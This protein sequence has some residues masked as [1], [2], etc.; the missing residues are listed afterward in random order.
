MLRKL[1]P[2]IGLL[3]IFAVTSGLSFSA[4]SRKEREIKGPEVVVAESILDGLRFRCIGPAIMGGRIDD[5]AVVEKKPGIIYAA[6]ASGGLWKTVNNGVTWEPIFDHETTSSIGDVAVSQSNPDIVWVGT[7][8]PNNRQSSSWGD[9]VFKSTDGGRTWKNMGLRETHHIGRVVIHPVNP[10]VVYVAA[11]GRLWG[12]N[13]ERGVYKTMDGGRTWANVKFIDEN[14]GFADVAMDPE[15]PDTLYAAAYE[16]RRTSFGFSGSGPGSG[17]YKTT[18]GGQTWARL[19]GGL[20]PGN[21]GRIGIDIYRGD[22]RIVYILFEHREGG[23]FRSEDKGLTWRKMSATNNRPMY[24]SQVRIDPNNDRHIWAAGASMYISDDGGRTF[25]TDVVTNIHGDYHAIWIDPADSDHML[26]GSDGGIHISY[27]R[28]LTWDF[29]NTIPLGQFY[30]V[31]F[32]MRQPYFVYGGLQDNG[33]WGGPN[34]TLFRLGVTNDEWFRVGGGDGFYAQVDPTDHNTVYAES[35]DGSVFRLDLRAWQSKSIRPRPEDPKETYRFNWNSPIL[36]SPH[37]PKKVYYGGNRLFV[38]TDRGDT[39]EATP[40]LTSQLDRNKLPILGLVP[41]SNMLSRHDGVSFYGTITTISESPVKPG[42]LWVG[43]DDGLIQVSEDN[44][45]TWKSVTSGISGVPK[46]TYVSRVNASRFA[47]GRAYVTFDGHRGDDFKPYVYMTEDFGGTWKNISAN[48]PVGSTVSVVRESLRNPDLLFAGT[49]RG[50]YFSVDRGGSWVMMKGNLPMVPVDDIAIHPRENDLI[51]ATHGRSIWV[52][53]DAAAFDELTKDTLAAGSRL[54]DIR[55]SMIYQPYGHKGS[56]GHKVYVAPN[57]PLGAMITYYLKEAAKDDPLIVISD[58]D[59]N[60][61]RTLK[62]TKTSGINR[63]V[64]DLRHESLATPA[65]GE[66][67]GPGRGQPAAPFVLPGEYKVS[68][69]AS[70]LETV[71]TA[72]VEADPRVEVNDEALKAQHDALLALYRLNPLMDGESSTQAELG[73]RLDELTRRIKTLPQVPAAVSE[74]LKAFQ[75]GLDAIRTELQGDPAAGSAG[76]AAS[77][78][79][80]M[81]LLSRDIA[82]VLAAPTPAQLKDIQAVAGRLKALGEGLN[83][84]IDEEIPK[85]NKT[86]NENNI[87]HL[88]PVPRIKL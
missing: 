82:A 51:F 10:D 5:F 28:G 83:R 19:T 26:A 40:D 33:S 49:E 22:P 59:G 62:G 42:I 29:V 50:A 18:D 77:L 15:N 53:D 79:N 37:D 2:I 63:I 13:K 24:Y 14:T 64:W 58:A 84:L 9:G 8:E 7:G 75:A 56:T 46:N 16:R 35:Q 48:I 76:M 55:A 87:P 65:V 70:G 54:F 45:K 78:R 86:L 44:A 4:Q 73:R 38:S 34:A 36:I 21:C 31:G 20:P 32:D 80:R 17:L 85:L 72:K 71:K 74:A 67:A 12:P 69:Q 6:T 3:T 57:P 1:K 11:L 41:D 81:T 52:L 23:I 47:E 43:T 27:D 66:Q 61:V 39:W 68:L 88:V 30:E 25:R 60:P